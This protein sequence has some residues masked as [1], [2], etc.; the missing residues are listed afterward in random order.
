MAKARKVKTEPQPAPILCGSELVNTDRVIREFKSTRADLENTIDRLRNTARRLADQQ[1][2]RALALLPSL[3]AEFEKIAPKL[4]N[5]LQRFLQFCTSV[6]QP[7]GAYLSHHGAC[8]VRLSPWFLLSVA[9][10]DYREKGPGSA[11]YTH[12]RLN[13]SVP[14]IFSAHVGEGSLLPIPKALY[15][16]IV[17]R[18]RVYLKRAGASSVGESWPSGGS[19]G[20]RFVAACRY[21]WLEAA[22]NQWRADHGAVYPDGWSG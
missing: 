10:H 15:E 3:S 12:F 19:V 18:V 17:S 9:I 1:N 16:E 22:R 8:V 7:A 11:D 13:L 14:E 6:D 5:E 20:C 4:L 21:S 2:A